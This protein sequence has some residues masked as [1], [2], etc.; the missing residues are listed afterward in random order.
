MIAKAEGFVAL[1]RFGLGAG[2][3]DLDRVG[4]DARGWTQAQL[5]RGS[6]L[7]PELADL[8]SGEQ[9]ARTLLAAIQDKSIQREEFRQQTRAL[10]LQEAGQR[11]LAAITSPTPLIER[12][13]HF[14]SNH[15]TVSVAGKPILAGLVGAYEREAIRPYV[16]G[17]FA[18]MLRAV[19]GH[20]AMLLYLDNATSVGPDSRAG[21]LRDK[22]LNENLARELLELHTLGVDGGYTQADVQEFAKIL[23]GWSVGRPKTAEAGTFQFHPMIHEPG[24]KTLLGKRYPEAGM[25]EGEAAL[26]DLAR[27]PATARHIATQ[28]ARHFIADQPPAPAVERLARV[29][30]DTDGDLAQLTRALIALPEAW[31]DPLA[32]VKTP[33]EFVVSALRLTTF[34]G[35]T[36]KL[37]GSL[38]LLGQTPFGAPSPAGW[39][40]TAA[41][42][43]GPEAIMQRIDWSMAL[44][45][46]LP[47]DLSPMTLADASIAPVA[48]RDTML[49]IQRAADVRE[50]L[51]LLF[52][53]RE[54]QR[55]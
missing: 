45:Q 40:D 2:L 5:D 13:V 50:G 20:P 11:T 22:G 46:R 21:R 39:P 27:H 1:T 14:W 26:R 52:A 16:T 33:T 7:P 42:W 49:A 17:R 9:Q 44:A 19:V 51:A 18:D 34:K 3:G 30:R 35:E 8:G 47:R 43:I 24:D 25:A 53:S 54:F 10:Y 36:E 31:A 38:T 37:V 15:F 41:D 23:T 12:L 55:R 32:K 48:A 29:F 6:Q 4:G 28:L